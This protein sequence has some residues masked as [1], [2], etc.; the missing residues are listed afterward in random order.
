MLGDIGDSFCGARP[1]SGTDYFFL[2]NDE[3]L[4]WNRLD[5]SV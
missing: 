3:V 5:L 4:K 2:T 1:G